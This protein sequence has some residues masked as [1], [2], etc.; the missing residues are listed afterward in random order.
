[1]TSPHPAEP[2]ALGFVLRDLNAQLKRVTARVSQLEAAALVTVDRANVTAYT[3]GST[4]C[5]VTYPDASTDVLGFV[6]TYTP[7]VGHDVL[8]VSSP[9]GGYVIGEPSV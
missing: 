9:L 2:G 7:V 8:V 1:V 4:Q 5:T 6:T 3:G